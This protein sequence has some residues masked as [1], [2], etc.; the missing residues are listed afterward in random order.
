MGQAAADPARSAAEALTAHHSVV[1]QAAVGP[2]GC[3]L[4]PGREL[5]I[6][7]VPAA[8]A[9]A[10]EEQETQMVQEVPLKVKVQADY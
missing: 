5:K 7:V 3:R 9:A 4:G 2:R 1:D 6:L 8:A 10:V